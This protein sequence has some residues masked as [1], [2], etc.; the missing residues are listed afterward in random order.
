M[1]TQEPTPEATDNVAQGSRSSLEVLA[2][3]IP[4]GTGLGVPLVDAGGYSCGNRAS[5]ATITALR[6][7]SSP[8]CTVALEAKPFGE[9]NPAQ[10]CTLPPCQAAT[11]D[12]SL[13]RQLLPTPSSCAL[14]QNPLKRIMLRNATPVLLRET[15]VGKRLL[16]CAFHEFDGLG[17]AQRA[18][19]IREPQRCPRTGSGPFITWQQ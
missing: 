14:A 7:N 2:M 16:G 11:Q 17:Q 13:P 18:P 9:E 10:P 19:I 1:N 4:R 15:A 12:E 5:G 6:D 8:A 3:I